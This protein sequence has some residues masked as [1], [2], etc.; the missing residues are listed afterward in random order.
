MVASTAALSISLMF[1]RESRDW[2][3]HERWGCITL[4]TALL[5]S[6]SRLRGWRDNKLCAEP[7]ASDGAM[8]WL[9][10]TL[11]EQENAQEGTRDGGTNSFNVSGSGE[12]DADGWLWH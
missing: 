12:M 8:R 1:Y 2:T 5:P 11:E 4:A 10:G 9:S 7:Y 3:G 6:E